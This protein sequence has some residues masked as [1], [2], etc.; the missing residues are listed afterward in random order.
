VDQKNRK[1]PSQLILIKKIVIA[2]KASHATVAEKE[3]LLI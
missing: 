3:K 2:E 1:P